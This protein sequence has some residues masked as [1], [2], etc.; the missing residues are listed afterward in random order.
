MGGLFDFD[1]EAANKLYAGLL[2]IAVI[3]IIAFFIKFAGFGSIASSNDPAKVENYIPDWLAYYSKVLEYKVPPDSIN[4]EYYP[5]I[6]VENGMQMVPQ[7]Y[8]NSAYGYWMK[9]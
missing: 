2:I 1:E 7:N 4:Y 8:E 6:N 3:L 5:N 9:I